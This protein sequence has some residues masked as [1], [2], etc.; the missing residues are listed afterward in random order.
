MSIKEK[1]NIDRQTKKKHQSSGK[2]LE[3][4][5]IVSYIRLSKVGKGLSAQVSLL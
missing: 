2:P 3:E 5:L 1:N 4:K